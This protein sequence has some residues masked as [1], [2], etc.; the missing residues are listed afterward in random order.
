MADVLM[1]LHAGGERS[2]SSS[3]NQDIDGGVVGD[4]Q[5]AEHN[6][7]PGVRPRLSSRSDSV[8]LKKLF[9]RMSRGASS[10]SSYP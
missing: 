5:R 1:M 7:I 10:H 9:K 2:S 4:A 3:T 6:N 8:E